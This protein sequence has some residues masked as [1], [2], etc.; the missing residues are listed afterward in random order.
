MYMHTRVRVGVAQLMT[1]ETKP[2]R[3]ALGVITTRGTYS[4]APRETAFKTKTHTP[5]HIRGAVHRPF[6]MATTTTCNA[7]TATVLYYM[8]VHAHVRTPPWTHSA[9]MHRAHRVAES[10]S[11]AIMLSGK[12]VVPAATHHAHVL[13]LWCVV[14]AWWLVGSGTRATNILSMCTGRL[15]YV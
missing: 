7:T 13:C 12:P 2:L 6:C 10:P 5:K 4:F 3:N 8:C 1:N 14:A 9:A 15:L 11:C